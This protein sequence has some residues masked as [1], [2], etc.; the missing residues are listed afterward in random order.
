MVRQAQTEA[1]VNV[2]G[3]LA[4]QGFKNLGEDRSFFGGK[5]YKKITGTLD[6]GEDTFT[7][8]HLVR[9]I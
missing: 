9:K 5:T 4:K 1:L 2:G 6:G 3:S 7:K 8:N